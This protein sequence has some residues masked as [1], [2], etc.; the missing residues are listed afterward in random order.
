MRCI[1]LSFG[2][3]FLSTVCNAQQ[4]KFYSG[5]IQDIYNML[6]VVDSLDSDKDT[7]VSCSSSLLQDNMPVLISCDKYGIIDHIGIPI[8]CSPEIRP[9]PAVSF[10]ERLFLEMLLFKDLTDLIRQYSLDDVRITVDG[11]LLVPQ[12]LYDRSEVYDWIKDSDIKSLVNDGRYYTVDLSNG[13]HAVSVSFKSDDNLVSGMSKNELDMQLAFQLM[14]HHADSL[15][16][17]CD[18]C[19]LFPELQQLNDSLFLDK[20]EFYNIPDINNDCIYL[21]TADS[22]AYSIVYDRSLPVESIS[23]ALLGFVDDDFVIDIQ[24]DTYSGIV[25]YVVTGRDFEDYF[26]GRYDRYFGVRNSSEN[27]L[28]GTLIL[29]DRYTR[30]LHMGVVSVYYDEF[31]DRKIIRMNLFSNI[32]DVNAR[33]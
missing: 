25:E 28:D 27:M 13:S 14:H 22:V 24:H 5:R 33:L 3:L 7:I 15:R 30:S 29:K 10:I 32:P 23:N 8:G 12:T 26:A 6:D 31:F 1:I 20:G 19:C 11:V 9:V 2:F 17:L 18:T 16:L 21:K 4:N